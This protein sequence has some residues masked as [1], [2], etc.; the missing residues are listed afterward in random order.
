[1]LYNPKWSKVRTRF[2]RFYRWLARQ[3]AD[4]SY[5]YF[6][7]CNCGYAQYLPSYGV[8]AIVGPSSWMGLWLGVVPCMGRVPHAIDNAL[9]M[10][11]HTFGA[12]LQRL[13]D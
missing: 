4:K 3:P 11:P 6:N 1:M 13:R 9:I 8:L 10:R 12:V 2:P 7:S 5:Q